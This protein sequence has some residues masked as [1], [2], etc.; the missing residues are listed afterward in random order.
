MNFRQFAFPSEVVYLPLTRHLATSFFVV[1]ICEKQLETLGYLETYE[2]DS[3][4][5][6][7]V[8]FLVLHH[9]SELLLEIILLYLDC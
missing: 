5:Y 4:L 2:R 3:F 1:A 6:Q 7:I 9:E 8:L